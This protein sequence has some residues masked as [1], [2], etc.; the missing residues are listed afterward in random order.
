M[1]DPNLV[2]KGIIFSAPTGQLAL[3]SQF[4]STLPSG[5]D[6]IAIVKAGD[7]VG[8]V[9][10]QDP[11]DPYNIAFEDQD[12]FQYY[13]SY[14]PDIMKVVDYDPGQ[15]LSNDVSGITGVDNGSSTIDIT[16][17]SVF[18]GSTPS[19]N[20]TTPVTTTPPIKTYGLQKP[21]YMKYL[22]Y[23]IGALAIIII[24]AILAH[25]PKETIPTP[26]PVK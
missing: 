1:S 21:S 15:K 24:I 22:P 18:P 13:T 7:P 3:Y 6:P 10:Q 23:A 26:A 4:F 12:G 25:H 20:G 5:S 19:A 11:K 14:E 2:G 16:S 17:T 9:I 8:V